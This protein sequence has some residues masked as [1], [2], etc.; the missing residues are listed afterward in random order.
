MT[1]KEMVNNIKPILKWVG[2]KRELI[3]FIREFYKNLKPNNYFEPF[4]G[5]GAVYLDI[6]NTFGIQFSNNS[7]VSDINSDLIELYKNIKTVPD[8]I[9]EACNKIEQLYIQNGY[10]YIR[11]RFNGID[12]EGKKVDKFEKIERSAALI[13]INRT[14]FNGLY[15]TNSKGLFNVPEGSYKNPK[16]LDIDNLYNLSKVL[17]KIDNIKNVQF[18]EI[19]DIKE[20]DLVYFDPPYHPLNPT[21]S[22][23][24]YSGSF[25]EK[26]QIKLRDYFKELDNLGVYVLLSNSAS[27]FIKELYSEFQINEVPCKRN[28]NSKGD[29][30]G[31]ITEYLIVG[32]TLLNA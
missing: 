29:K 4:Y 23:T 32:N 19:V 5:G 26:E 6:I 30:R 12:R 10:Y 2:G 13:L 3:P 31:K 28:I 18:N 9:E 20:G 8:K 25:G 7:I 27:Q 1:K 17:P 24:S 14:C 22:F 15:R 21:S 16:I 11:D